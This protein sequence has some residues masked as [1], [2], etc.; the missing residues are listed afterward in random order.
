MHQQQKSANS[1]ICENMAKE[2]SKI[3]NID[4]MSFLHHQKL[5]L[6]QFGLSLAE[7]NLVNVSLN[8][9][10]FI[11]AFNKFESSFLK[12]NIS[13][14]EIEE[15]KRKQ[16]RP[17]VP[18]FREAA[19]IDTAAIRSL[20]VESILCAFSSKTSKFQHGFATYH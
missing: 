17:K 1:I 12:E 20:R 9:F 11:D 2:F 13:V 16:A 4:E 8:K 14:V 15:T 7:T 10:L 5:M 3:V 6:T 18:K 19:Q